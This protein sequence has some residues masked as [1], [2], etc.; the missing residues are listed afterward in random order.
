MYANNYKYNEIISAIVDE[1]CKNVVQHITGNTNRLASYLKLEI[2][3]G[4]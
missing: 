2:M 3:V 4:K 1:K